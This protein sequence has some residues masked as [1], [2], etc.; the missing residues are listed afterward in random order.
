MIILPS[1]CI[2]VEEDNYVCRF[3]FIDD[4]AFLPTHCNTKIKKQIFKNKIFFIRF[5]RKNQHT[6]S[7]NQKEKTKEKKILINF[8]LKKTFYNKNK[9]QS[10]F[11]AVINRR[12]KN[13]ILNFIL[14]TSMHMT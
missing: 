6:P 9:V 1:S 2:L 7:V 12:K 8:T 11:A 4:T 5:S 10:T 3:V 13:L 14:F